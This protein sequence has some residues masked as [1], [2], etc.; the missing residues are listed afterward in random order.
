MSQTLQRLRDDPANRSGP[1]SKIWLTLIVGLHLGLGVAFGLATPVFEAPDE[2][3][4]F[5]FIRYL[6]IYHTLPAQT[7]N[8]DGPR[9]H[10]PPLYFLVAALVSAGVGDAGGAERITLPENG[11]LWFRYGAPAIDHKAKFIHAPEAS[12]P[13]RGM[14]LAV[15]LLRVLS[16]VFSAL[17]VW[18]TYLAARNLWPHAQAMPLLAAAVLGFNPMALFMSGVV[19]NSA[20]ALASSAALLYALSHWLRRGFTL[21]RWAGLGALFSV[22]VLVQTSGL[23]LA[24]PVATALLYEGW[25]SRQWKRLLINGLAFSGPVL[26]LTGWWFI[27][28]H[29]L[30]GDWT[31]N[32]IVA[33]LWADQP[34]M[35]LE[36]TWYLLTTGMVGRFG[37]GLIIE[38]ADTVYR[39]AWLIVL[40]AALGLIWRA[41][42]RLKTI[43]RDDSTALWFIH[44]ITVMAV[45]AGLGVYI[46]WYIRGGHG[47]Y[48][49]TAYPSL[50]LLLAAGWLA[51]LRPRWHTVGVMVGAGLSLGLSLYG[52]CGLVIP[53]YRVPRSPTPA[54][55]RALTPLDAKVGDVAQ[56]SGYRLSARV[57]KPGQPLKVTVYWQPQARTPI[58]YTVFVQLV[59]PGVGL[60]AQQ[61]TYPGHG[62]WATTIWAIG[63]PFV[64]TYTLHIPETSEPLEQAFV[65]VGLYD[66]ATQQRLPVTG[67][68]AGSA[69]DRWVQFGDVR[70][71][72]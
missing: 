46:I 27:R 18:F 64:D 3:N 37:F 60:I 69:N 59:H 42:S 62:N 36:Q 38:Y 56:V 39:V 44:I 23:T 16:A 55:V 45:A 17:A 70:L 28:N 25:R 68:N 12:W 22:A 48:M 5:L 7:L 53:A 9:A 24:A 4:H 34:I 61:D 50:A 49:F 72:P 13:W 33:A 11:D 20:A 43:Q 19:Q 21:A 29:W 31:A 65:V 57:I 1:S 54:E 47:R 58:P 6:Q 14:M 15:H 8:Q 2:A 41:A 10:H 30:Y 32:T 35:P 40:V 71:E 63:R 66:A 67:A 26:A 52:L 51:W